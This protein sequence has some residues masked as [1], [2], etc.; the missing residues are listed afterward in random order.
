MWSN[1]NVTG[2]LTISLSTFP[3]LPW[4]QYTNNSSKHDVTFVTIGLINNLIRHPE[5][6]GFQETSMNC[7]LYYSYLYYVSYNLGNS[8]V[9]G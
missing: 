3:D 7:D 5:T 8:L 1:I 4:C 2:P 6:P 9:C